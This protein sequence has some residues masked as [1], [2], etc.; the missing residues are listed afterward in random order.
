MD[1]KEIERRVRLL[2]EK[3]G[4][5]MSEV[6]IRVAAEYICL[7]ADAMEKFCKSFEEVQDGR[8]NE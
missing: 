5:S 2:N 4:L 3:R 1:K 8:G 7:D 6:A